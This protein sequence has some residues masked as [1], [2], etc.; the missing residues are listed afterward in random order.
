MT[1]LDCRPGIVWGEQ[2]VG[3][4]KRARVIRVIALRRAAAEPIPIQTE[5]VRSRHRAPPLY[6]TFQDEARNLPRPSLC[7]LAWCAC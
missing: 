5:D 4:V 6:T 7:D 1:V 2:R 3:R